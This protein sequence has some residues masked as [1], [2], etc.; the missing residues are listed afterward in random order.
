[1]DDMMEICVS[2]LPMKYGLDRKVNYSV[3][4]RL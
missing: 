4:L 3:P 2:I 1:M